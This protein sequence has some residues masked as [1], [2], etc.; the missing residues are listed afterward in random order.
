MDV[1][2]CAPDSSSAFSGLAFGADGRLYASRYHLGEVWQ[3]DGSS[4]KLLGTLHCPGDTHADYLGFGPDGRLYVS[5]LSPSNAS[6]FDV[7]TG[8]CLGSYPSGGQITFIGKGF[9]FFPAADLF[10]R[11]RPTTTTVHQGDLITYAFPVWNLGP[12]N[13]DFEVLNTQVPA[14]TTFDYIRISGT[15]GL[16]TCTHPP[17]QETGQIVCYE[18]SNMAPNTTWTV[19]LTVKVTAA[20]GTV[21]LR[22]KILLVLDLSRLGRRVK[23]CPISRFTEFGVFPVLCPIGA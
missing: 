16:G 21:R 1:F 13:A 4:G 17:Y 10:L 8:Q 5:N 2:A 20:P 7:H 12:S 9:V 11:I 15:P 6:R 22:P 18:N 3:L 14:G 23:L 19:R